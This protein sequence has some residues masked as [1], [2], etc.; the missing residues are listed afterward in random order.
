MTNGI[1]AAPMRSKIAGRIFGSILA[2]MASTI[3]APVASAAPA[4]EDWKFIVAPYLWGAALEGDV[5]VKGQDAQVELSASDIFDHLDL[6]AMA[7][8]VARK[9]SWGIAADGVW[10]DLEVESDAPPADLQPRLGIFTLQAVRRL[11][12]I[13]D[14]TFGVRYNRLEAT[15]D[16]EA[17]INMEVSNTRDWVDPVV[18]IVLRTPGEHRWHAMLIA[19][20]GGFGVGSD[21]AWQ[22]FPSVGFDLAKWVSIE[23]GY[24][25]LSTDYETGDDQD[26]FAYDMLYQG[27]AVGVAFRF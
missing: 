10:V 12:D 1:H 8:F 19:D 22:A 5:T 18:G 13:A 20:V 25:F 4:S 7:M 24:R 9:G 6:G 26:R 21:F 23:V 3:V 14:L 2:L 16:F 17:P 27:P 11:S 15:I